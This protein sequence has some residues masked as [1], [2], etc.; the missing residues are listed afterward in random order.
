MAKRSA[1]DRRV[2]SR[3]STRLPAGT[4]PGTLSPPPGALPSQVRRI[5]Y[6]EHEML[7]HD[8]RDLS[9]LSDRER[10]Y[11]VTW[12]DVTGLGTTDTIRA[13]GERFGLHPLALEDVVHTHQRPKVE[14]YPSG[15]YL[16]V[17]VPH[18]YADGT[19]ELEQVSIFLGKD[20][21]VTFQ[22]REGDCFEPVRERLRRSRGKLRRSGPDYLAYALIDA[23]VD[24]FFP[25]IETYG[26]TLDELQDRILETPDSVLVPQ[27]H[28]IRR[29]LLAIRRTV[30]P[31]RDALST[32]VRE[33]YAAIG[34]ETRLYLR[35]VNDHTVQLVELT[36]LHREVASGLL[37]IYLSSMS[38]RMNEVMKVLT[39]IATIF[40]PLS[41]VASI[42]GMNFERGASAWNMPE[43]GWA[44]GYPFALGLM[45]SIA[46][47]LLA[48]FRRRGWI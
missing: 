6:D 27:I 18:A 5:A 19:L 26:D 17:R 15:L 12:V 37:D 4:M 43:L 46:I 20:Y 34:G 30:W 36:E 10:A 33:E 38:N 8:V 31:L 44:Y 28:G 47:A 3:R 1:R 14:E 11:A 24:S 32:L 35:D 9:S 22:E 42:Y 16:A 41:F 7:E 23:V 2:Q 39:I 29:D 21:V 48:F 25:H 40:I 13:V 45:A